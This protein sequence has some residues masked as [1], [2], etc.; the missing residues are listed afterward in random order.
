MTELG[1]LSLY[2]CQNPVHDTPQW[3]AAEGCPPH[4]RPALERLVNGFPVDY[5]N[6]PITGESFESCHRTTLRNARRDEAGLANGNCV[7]TG[8]PD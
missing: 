3:R 8:F 2:A 4:L 7:Q 5:L 1:P 6:P